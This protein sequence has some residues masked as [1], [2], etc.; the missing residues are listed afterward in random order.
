M[1]NNQYYSK[2]LFL[3]PILYMILAFHHTSILRARYF[4]PVLLFAVF[5]SFLELS[6]KNKLKI[7][8]PAII[9]TLF[10]TK[11]IPTPFHYL[12]TTISQS[13]S[14]SIILTI[15]FILSSTIFFSYLV[16]RLFDKFLQVK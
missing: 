12:N 15:I 10:F 11:I 7:I 6:H 4:G 14:T 1:K 8:A 5:I 13:M 16:S 2:I 3:I 9:L